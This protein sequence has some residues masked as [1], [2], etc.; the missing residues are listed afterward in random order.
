MSIASPNPKLSATQVPEP[1][2]VGGKGVVVPVV[3][4]DPDVAG[5]PVVAGESVVV[6]GDSVV[7]GL[8]LKR[9]LKY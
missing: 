3:V 6:A 7:V 1:V 8:K 4:G 5:D 9:G 2:V